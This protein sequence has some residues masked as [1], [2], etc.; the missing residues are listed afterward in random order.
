MKC[1]TGILSNHESPLR[2]KHFVTQKIIQAAIAINAG[3]QDQLNLGNL[4]IHRDWGWSCEYVSAMH[5][6]LQSN[7]YDDY[8]IATGRTVSLLDFVENAFSY[9]DLD[10]KKYVKI[11][12]LLTRP[13][14]LRFSAM[15][16]DK[17]RQH[18][19]WSAQSTINAM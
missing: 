13:S 17:I 3:S 18:L 7:N 9:F 5:L 8:I 12:E 19:G 2:P 10:Y 16:P 4:D 15:N 11:N 14:E 6:M 1:C